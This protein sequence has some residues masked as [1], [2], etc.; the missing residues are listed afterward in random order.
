M[1]KILYIVVIAAVIVFIATW[2][3]SNERATQIASFEEC[4]AAGYEVIEGEP[5]KCQTE[6]GLVFSREVTDNDLN[7]EGDMRDEESAIE[8]VRNHLATRLG[9][10]VDDLD[11]EVTTTEREWPD[12]CLGLAEEDEM[13]ASVIVFGYEVVLQVDGENYV[14]HTDED[15]SH[16]RAV[17]E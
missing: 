7:G 10:S 14:Y 13:C 11:A 6:E 3:F 5:D 12:A 17:A 4:V 8:A 15:G 9:V 1:K 16:F 2:L